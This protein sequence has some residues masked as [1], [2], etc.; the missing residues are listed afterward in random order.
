MV[1]KMKREASGGDEGDLNYESLAQDC[2]ERQNI[3]M[4]PRNQSYNILVKNVA[5]FCYSP[6]KIWLGLN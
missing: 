5:D 2:S 6:K 3:S 1:V 4:Y